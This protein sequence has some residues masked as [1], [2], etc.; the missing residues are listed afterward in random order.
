MINFLHLE[1]YR[2]NN[3]IEAKKATGG[4]PYSL[5]ETY[6][7]FAN[8]LGGVILL[9]V[10]EYKDTSLHAV[11]LPDPDKT[12]K[13]FWEGVNEK[14]MVSAKILTEKDVQKVDY[15]GKT[16]VAI[17]VPRAERVNRPVYMGS[18]PYTGTYRRGGEGDYRCNKEQIT[19]MIKD[20]KRTPYDLGVLRRTRLSALDFDCV[21]DYRL[22]LDLTDGYDTTD[23]LTDC[24]LLKRI[25]AAGRAKDNNLHPTAAGLLCFGKHGE[26]LKQFPSFSLEYSDG[27]VA[28]SDKNAETGNLYNFFFAVSERLKFIGQGRA[29]YDALKEALLNAVVNANY[30]KFGGV[31]VVCTPEEVRIINA[32]NL[33][34]APK[35]A[36]KKG[37]S[38]SRNLGVKAIFSRLGLGEGNGSGLAAIYALWRKKGWATPSFYEEFDPD[39]ITLKLSFTAHAE[40]TPR[41]REPFKALQ[42]ALLISYL[43]ETRLANVNEI[44]AALSI[45]EDDAA[46]AV[47]RLISRK[48]V[49]ADGDKFK[50]A[51]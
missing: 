12:V 42:S 18:D 2:E 24:G 41:E 40:V 31:R 51:R 17:T 3:R 10:E 7:S 6:S 26:I 23:N 46:L 29:V 50:L 45:S 1:E 22:R 36:L 20:A 25:G 47:R 15:N 9:G 43:T 34:T 14:K 33:P 27:E 8:T 39:S 48:L 28:F 4:F 16:V 35:K 13:T 30:N 49:V 5:W 37:V 38:D 19:A 11:G 44:A 32:G 21:K